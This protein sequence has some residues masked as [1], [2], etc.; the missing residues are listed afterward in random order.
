M[1]GEFKEMFLIVVSIVLFFDMFLG[2]IFLIFLFL[3]FCIVK[4]IGKDMFCKFFYKRFDFFGKL[5][6]EDGLVEI[7]S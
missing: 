5:D 1:E 4:K 6:F 3:K 2:V 7:L